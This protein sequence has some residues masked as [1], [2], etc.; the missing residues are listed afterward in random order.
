MKGPSNIESCLSTQG[1]NRQ[2]LSQKDF[3]TVK[4]PDL[5]I[6]LLVDKIKNIKG[7]D[8]L[9]SATLPLNK[10]YLQR[11]IDVVQGQMNNYLFSELSKFD[12]DS[13]L[14]GFNCERMN[15]HGTEN[16]EASFVSKNEHD[17]QKMRLYPGKKRKWQKH[18]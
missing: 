4:N 16:L 8:Q 3:N 5:F 10:N 2:N 15:F 14:T 6:T 1:Y 17:P 9:N 12:E 7:P 11:L 13:D 18:V